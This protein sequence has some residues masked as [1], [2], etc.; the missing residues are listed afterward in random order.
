MARLRVAVLGA[1]EVHRG[2]ERLVFPTRKTLA[3]LLYLLVERAPQPRDKLITLFWPESTPTAARST[4][5]STLVRLRE[6]L[7]EVPGDGY[8]V[9]DRAAV[10]FAGSDVE[11]DLDRLDAAY[12]RVR[13]LG[14][15]R[16]AVADLEAV[17]ADLRRAAEVW[18]GDFLDG[19]ALPDAPEFDDWVAVQRELQRRRMGVVLDRLSILEADSGAGARA[20]EAV[21][22]WLRLDPLEER[23]H[24]RLMRLLAMRGDRAGALAAYDA[25]RRVL[26]AELGVA[27]DPETDA[28]AERIRSAPPAVRRPRPPRHGQPDR[29]DEAPLVGRAEEFAALVEQF[30]AAARGRTQAVVLHGEAG[31]GKTRLATEFLAWAAAQGAEVLQGRAFEASARL[32][33]QPLVDAIRPRLEREA[34]PRSLLSPVWLSELSRLLPELRERRF[35]LPAPNGDEASARVRLF[36]TVARLGRSLAAEAPLVLVVDDVQWADVASLDVAHYAARRWVQ[37]AAAVLLLC[38]VRAEAAANAALDAWLVGLS[39]ALATTRIDLGPLSPG[40]T[41]E[42]VHGFARDRSPDPV[43]D[44]FAGW[45]FAETRGQPLYIVETLR[46]LWDREALP[47]PSG[48]A[49]GDAE[50]RAGPAGGPLA[51]PPGVQRVIQAR[52]APL[53]PAARELLAAAAVLGQGFSFELLCQVGHV[54]E[55][56]ALPALDALLRGRLLAAARDPDPATAAERYHFTH[57]NI[58]GVAYA[59]AGDARRRVFH[60]RALEALEAGG[61]PPAELARHALAAGL[62]DPALRFSLA[63]GDGAM[64]LLAARDAAVHFERAVTLAARLDRADLLPELHARRGRAFVGMGAWSEARA[65][66]ETALA[67]LAGGT[68]ERHAEVLTEIAAACWWQLDVPAVLRYATDAREAAVATGRGDLETEAVAWRAA[69]AGA[70]GNLALCGELIERAKRRAG[71]LGLAAP[72]IAGHYHPLTLYWLGRPDEAV[73]VAR[74]AVAVAR[75][76][77]DISWLMTALPN[78]GLALAATGRY[79]GAMPVFAEARGLGREYGLDPLLARAI[80]SS[81]GFH[82]DLFDLDGAESLAHEA[83]ELALGAGFLPP[84]VSAGID[85]LQTY[86]QTGEIAKTERLVDEVTAAI[87]ET[88]GFHRWQWRMRLAAA[89]AAIALVRGDAAG[90]LAWADETI[91][92]GRARGRLKYEAIGL[93]LRAQQSAALGRTTQA[94]ADLRAALDLANQVGDP[95]LVLRPAAALLPLDGDE[96]LATAAGAAVDRIAAAL[97]DPA[98]RRRFERADAVRAIRRATGPR[99]LPSPET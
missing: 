5:R 50:L 7:E 77:H 39:G 67:G 78:L 86:A 35:G 60:R 65:A 68:R 69:A 23:A 52:L 21:D 62:D 96:S 81:A 11:R 89:R 18:R 94:T 64:A 26:A 34:E 98:M 25:C 66:F 22:L 63:A 1:P 97:L 88:G 48:G 6:R 42:L 43:S 53:P 73:P 2:H 20:E 83:R 47:H 12:R 16:P 55:D 79:E 31:I 54:A 40:E 27:T 90:A 80:A 57:D 41:A 13:A 14:E 87:E 59:E 93:T 45:V 91:A 4:L 71:E 76:R 84:V 32:P 10:A 9:A 19:F 70:L 58:R 37:E 24:R 33:Y 28:L 15:T 44:S 29:P 95:A 30:H 72:T 3:V 8:L 38:C 46:S 99:R 61:A 92:Q 85:L 17:V 75:E 74:E 49:E 36:E 56:A 82:N 51:L